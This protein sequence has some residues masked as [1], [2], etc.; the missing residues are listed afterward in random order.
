MYFGLLYTGPI[1]RKTKT[2]SNA[3]PGAYKHPSLSD[4]GPGKHSPQ[5]MNLQQP[6]F[7]IAEIRNNI[8]RH[9]PPRDLNNCR[10]LSKDINRHIDASPACQ[11]SLILRKQD[12]PPYH[13]FSPTDDVEHPDQPLSFLGPD[14]ALGNLLFCGLTTNENSYQPPVLRHIRSVPVF[15]MVE[16]RDGSATLSSH[17]GH[18]RRLLLCTDGEPLEF[19]VWL[20][21]DP[22]KSFKFVEVSVTATTLGELVNEIEE[23]FRRKKMTSA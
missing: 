21:Q 16:E 22:R 10:S 13:F 12:G 3:L 6:V 17:A 23:A 11:K 1:N 5:I 9:L 2:S 14:R 15:L 18:W 19:R 7:K 4:T 20:M 8:L